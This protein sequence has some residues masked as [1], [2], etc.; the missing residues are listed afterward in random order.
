MICQIGALWRDSPENPNRGKESKARKPKA[1]SG[2][3][4]AK[5]AKR[6]R[7]ANKAKNS[8]SDVEEQTDEPQPEPAA[9]PQAEADEQEEA[10]DD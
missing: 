3:E 1:A 9:E 6:G 8:S 10:S 4:T 7:P 2:E 5:P